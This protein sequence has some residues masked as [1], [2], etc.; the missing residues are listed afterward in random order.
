MMTAQVDLNSTSLINTSDPKWQASPKFKPDKDDKWPYPPEKDGWVLAHN[1][2][3]NDITNFIQAVSS[4][5]DRYSSSTS[6]PSWSIVSI[7][8]FWS[9][10]YSVVTSHHYHEDEIVTPFMKKRVILP[11]KLEAD[12]EIVIEK[13]N[14]ISNYINQLTTDSNM[15]RVE[16]L[17]HALRS[18]KEIMFPHL[19]EEEM[20]SLPLLR[21]YFT[22]K[23]MRRAMLK[24]L[25]HAMTNKNESGALI[26]SMGIE[27]FRSTFMKQEGIPSFMWHLKFKSD[28]NYFI[29]NMQSHIDALNKGEPIITE[30]ATC[31]C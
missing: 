13:S 5:N 25:I 22:P 8:K 2:I 16:E 1:M 31:L 19:L 30:K 7:Q 6:L 20:I 28:Y 11:D 21:S 26:H 14:Q 12:H 29:R 10:H 18:Y 27:Y 15:S 4:I 9:H 24:I 23:E 17:L 3:R